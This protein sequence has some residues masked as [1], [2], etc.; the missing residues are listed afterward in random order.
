MNIN[1]HLFKTPISGSTPAPNTEVLENTIPHA[2]K[3]LPLQIGSLYYDFNE[4]RG[5]GGQAGAIHTPFISFEGSVCM[6]L[7]G[8]LVLGIQV[9]TPPDTFSS[10]SASASTDNL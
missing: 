7:S 8:G 4:L 6:S 10:S 3:K 1:K 2:T 5:S 9:E